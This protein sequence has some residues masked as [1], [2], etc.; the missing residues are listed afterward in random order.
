MLQESF[1]CDSQQMLGR[2]LGCELVDIDRYVLLSD[3]VMTL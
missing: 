1:A 2:Y 3:A